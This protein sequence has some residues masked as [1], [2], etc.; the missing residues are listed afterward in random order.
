MPKKFLLIPLVIVL[1]TALIFG[2]CKPEA[3]VPD[4]ILMGCTTSLTGPVAG[5]GMGGSFGVE[6]AVDDINKLGGVYVE[7]YGK[8]IPVRVL[9]VNSESD[10]IKMGTLAED[11]ILGSKVNVMT[12]G[13]E[14]PHLN[15]PVANVTE[16]YKVPNFSGIGPM[17]PWL[18][19][20]SEVTPTWKYTWAMGFSIATPAPPGDFRA[21]DPGYLVM[22]TWLNALG[23]HG[24]ETN[25]KVA[26]CGCDDPDGRGWYLG[27]A[28]AAVDAGYDVYGIDELFG[29]YAPGTTDFTPLIQEWMDYG[30]EILWGNWPPPDY[31]TMMRQ[32]L[33]QGFKP[34]VA[35]ASK[36]ALFYPDVAAWGGDIPLGVSLE[37]WWDP[38]IQDSP[39]IG[40]TTPQS[41][42]DKWY[43]ETGEPMN[44]MLGV[45]YTTIQ[46]FVDAIE[47]A[48]TLDGDAINNAIG[49]TDMMTIYHRVKFDQEDQF[50]RVP[51]SFAQWQKVN[52]PE[53]WEAKIVASYNDFIPTTGDFIF[54]IP[55]D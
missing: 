8:R 40:D 28:P 44:Q 30:C 24:D 51:V 17:E 2:G 50:N 23:A 29:L 25:K 42:A 43:E 12:T 11:L 10:P 18:G 31:G 26:A 38:S 15:S 39:G 52:K 47:R 4:E 41:L 55:Y 32:A 5:A 35:F 46:V 9:V 37:W 6:A 20:R 33:V 34:K 13:I 19:L 45:G 48:G 14:P 21:G 49:E 36:A 22:D 3:E 53:V 7:E 1:V 27:F 16:R 54:P